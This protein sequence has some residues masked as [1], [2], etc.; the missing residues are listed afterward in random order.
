MIGCSLKVP[1][2]K[3]HS[4]EQECMKDSHRSLQAVVYY[5]VQ[6]SDHQLHILC[7]ALRSVCEARLAHKLET[8]YGLISAAGMYVN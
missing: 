5:W 2:H 6:N 4:I 3:L 1:T 8:K 7:D